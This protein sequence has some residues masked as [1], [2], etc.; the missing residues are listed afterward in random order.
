MKTNS[1]ERRLGI[2]CA[3]TLIAMRNQFWGG[4]GVMNLNYTLRTYVRPDEQRRRRLAWKPAAIARRSGQ[5]W[6][7]SVFSKQPSP[8]VHRH[9]SASVPSSCATY[10]PEKKL[11]T[12]MMRLLK[13]RFAVEI[14][15]RVCELQAPCPQCYSLPRNSAH[16]CY[17]LYT[18]PLLPLLPNPGAGPGTV[19]KKNYEKQK[20]NQN[21]NQNRHHQNE[22]RGPYIA[23]YICRTKYHKQ[24]FFK[25]QKCIIFSHHQ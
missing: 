18:T 11:R 23:K 7:R 20:Q 17:K 19:C 10:S 4:W 9:P 12:S 14:R 16:R 25:V 1:R 6:W 24:S 21:S 5:S 3:G 22:P 13:L 8:L 2:N 15:F